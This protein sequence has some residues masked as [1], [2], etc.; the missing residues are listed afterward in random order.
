MK[1][2]PCP[3]SAQKV[4]EEKQPDVRRLRRAFGGEGEVSRVMLNKHPMIFFLQNDP[5]SWHPGVR[6]RVSGSLG[7][8]VPC[9]LAP[10]SFIG[11]KELI[12]SINE[13][14]T[15]DGDVLT[16]YF[17][18]KYI[19]TNGGADRHTGFGRYRA[20]VPPQPETL[21][22]FMMAG[23]LATASRDTFLRLE[24]WRLG[25]VVCVQGL[26]ING[27]LYGP[28]RSP[29]PLPTPPVPQPSPLQGLV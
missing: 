24:P 1:F 18:D 26:P 13:I 14:S 20:K 23:M 6:P 7:K 2:P 16:N 25:W 17:Q 22:S 9:V 28:S 5:F 19:H 8:S 15:A 4:K 21:R 11:H 3:G 29:A 12:L 10:Y 27:L